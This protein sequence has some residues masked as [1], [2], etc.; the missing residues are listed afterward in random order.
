MFK[1]AYGY[2][3]YV[4]L[5]APLTAVKKFITRFFK[6]KYISNRINICDLVVSHNFVPMLFGCLERL[7]DIGLFSET[8][9]M[10]E[11]RKIYRVKDKDVTG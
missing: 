6:H 1:I 8:N 5:S 3:V 4:A 7:W 10:V 11:K 9:P 2:F